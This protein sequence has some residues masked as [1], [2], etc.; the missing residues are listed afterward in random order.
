MYLVHVLPDIERG[1]LTRANVGEIAD[2]RP[3]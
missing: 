2:C 1:R 3:G